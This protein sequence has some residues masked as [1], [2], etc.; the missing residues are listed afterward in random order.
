MAIAGILIAAWLWLGKR[1]LVTSIANSAPGRLLG[2]GWYN[3]RGFDWLYDK[4]FKVK[5]FLG[6]AAVEARPANALMNIPAIL[7]VLQ[8]KARTSENGYLVLV[9]GIHEHRRGCC[10]RC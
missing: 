10:W 9:C 4:L 3:A 7:S 5:P 8:A 6:I 2:P 1:T